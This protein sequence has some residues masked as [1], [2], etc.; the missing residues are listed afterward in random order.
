MTALRY[1]PAGDAVV[2][3]FVT[4]LAWDECLHSLT[5]GPLRFGGQQLYVRVQG[6][7]VLVETGWQQRPTE[8]MPG[9]WLLRFEGVLGPED[10]GTRV[11]GQVVRNSTLETLLTVPG[12]ITSVFAVLGIALAVPFVA[13]LSVILL[14]LFATY[15]VYF[16]KLL[17][18]QAHD[19]AHWVV[20]R[21]MVTGEPGQS[22]ESP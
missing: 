17:N 10:A 15:Y 9:L 4:A 20:A 18:R 12:L 21:L 16:Q 19:L 6:D 13:V 5:H 3:E 2:V 22:R 8:G 11:V 7:R 1:P 14:V